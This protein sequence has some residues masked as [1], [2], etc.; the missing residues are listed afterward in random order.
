MFI[1]I[2]SIKT[3]IKSIPIV[4][5]TNFLIKKRSIKSLKCT[6]FGDFI[7]TISYWYNDELHRIDGPAK[8][9]V[10]DMTY[11]VSWFNC[12]R[13]HR[14][15]GPARIQHGVDNGYRS[16]NLCSPVLKFDKNGIFHNYIWFYNGNIHRENAPASIN[17]FENGNISSE[18]WFLHGDWRKG[19][20]PGYIEYK[21]DGTVSLKDYS[22]SPI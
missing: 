18:E 7:L 16:I 3:T 20:V 10:D 22:T 4:Y 13:E 14:I 9:Y 1:F 2:K 5:G 11:E 6:I 21:E 17:F 15:N 8:I 12:G 19:H